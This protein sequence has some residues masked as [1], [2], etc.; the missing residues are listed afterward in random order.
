MTQAAFS[1]S[2]L[3]RFT[4]ERFELVSSDVCKG[5][6]TFECY[7]HRVCRPVGRGLYRFKNTRKPNWLSLFRNELEYKTIIF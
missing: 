2:D 7:T 1:N 4:V 3:R 5:T 6:K